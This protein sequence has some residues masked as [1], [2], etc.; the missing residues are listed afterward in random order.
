VAAL[1]ACSML[2]DV[3]TAYDILQEM[4][5]KGFPMTEYIYNELIRVYGNATRLER[6]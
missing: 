5:L 2:G 4:K 6:V 3:T 1:K